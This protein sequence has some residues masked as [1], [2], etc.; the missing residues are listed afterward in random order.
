MIESFSLFRWTAIIHNNTGMS[1]LQCK[2]RERS[3]TNY[4]EDTSEGAEDVSGLRI[5]ITSSD[6]G[7]KSLIATRQCPPELR[8]YCLMTGHGSMTAVTSRSHG[9][10]CGHCLSGGRAFFWQFYHL[11]FLNDH[12]SGAN[13]VAL[14]NHDGSTYIYA[15]K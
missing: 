6:I 8:R 7:I 1:R 14:T 3:L 2:E 4:Q 9:V 12:M 11:P 5:N 13:H 10:N 15:E